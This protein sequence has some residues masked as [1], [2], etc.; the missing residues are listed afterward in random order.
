MT[1]NF[2][3][4]FSLISSLIFSQEKPISSISDSLLSHA[5]AVI[6]NHTENYTINSVKDMEI[7]EE[8]TISILSS[9]G[10][11]FS[12]IGIPYNPTTRV[13]DI[14]GFIYNK[15]GKEISKFY[16]KDFSDTS[17]NS[18]NALYVD[19]RILFYKPVAMEYPYTIKYS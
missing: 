19:D 16:K 11:G 8:M 6:R 17:N 13:S 5:Y 10:E 14:K 4:F 15:D 7:K 18:S 2:I 9:S 3:F 1:R 12:V